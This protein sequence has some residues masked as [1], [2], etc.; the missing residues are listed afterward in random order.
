MSSARSRTFLR[1]RLRLVSRPSS[2]FRRSGFGFAGR[3]ANLEEGPGGDEKQFLCGAEF[4][5]TGERGGGARIG[6]DERGEGSAGR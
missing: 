6:E 3:V 4:P 1:K 2:R 5:S